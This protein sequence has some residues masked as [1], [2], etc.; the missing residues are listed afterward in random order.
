[1]NVV[2]KK[3]ASLARTQKTVAL[4]KMAVSFV[5]RPSS[6]R[7]VLKNVRK[8]MSEVIFFRQNVKIV[9]FVWFRNAQTVT[10]WVALIL[11][12]VGITF[13]RGTF[14]P[15][16]TR[17]ATRRANP[18]SILISEEIFWERIISRRHVVSLAD[19]PKS[20]QSLHGAGTCDPREEWPKRLAASLL[21]STLE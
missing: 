18:H 6:A 7:T 11:P 2:L 10:L 19:A 1:M 15:S 4:T 14:V 16:A 12:N 8:T 3:A 9:G 13:A 17:H 5:Q 21:E 20:R